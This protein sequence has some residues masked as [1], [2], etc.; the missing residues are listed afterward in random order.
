MKVA[1]HESVSRVEEES[2]GENES[3]KAGTDSPQEYHAPPTPGGLDAHRFWSQRSSPSFS[4]VPLGTPSFPGFYQNA[5]YFQHGDNGSL[6]LSQLYSPSFPVAPHYHSNNY[7][8]PGYSPAISI[9][10]NGSLAPP[11]RRGSVNYFGQVHT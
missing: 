8:H 6:P 3:S 9:D 7:V 1:E 2:L 11:T 10:R 5:Q 4:N